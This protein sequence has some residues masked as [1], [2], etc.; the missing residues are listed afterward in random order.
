MRLPVLTCMGESF[1][2]R[3]AASLLTQLDCLNWITHNL[4]QYEAKAIELANDPQKFNL[5]KKH[6]NSQ[7]EQSDLFKPSHFAKNLEK[8]YQKIWQAYCNEIDLNLHAGNLT[9]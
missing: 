9:S 3:V 7:I 5:I 2:S 8:H 1:A 6:L 4:A